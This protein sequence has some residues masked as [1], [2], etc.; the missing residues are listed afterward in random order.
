MCESTFARSDHL[1]AHIRT[2]NNNNNNNN[3]NITV[4]KGTNLDFKLKTSLTTKLNFDEHSITSDTKV[5]KDENKT[6]HCPYCPRVC[7][8]KHH[9]IPS[10][11]FC[12]FHSQ[13]RI[14]YD[15]IFKMNI[16]K[17]WMMNLI[18]IH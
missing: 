16:I 18:L 12:S 4:D 13:G 11:S 2:H 1:K 7:L 14:V 17:T 15:C 9:E 6:A 10:F 8:G 5:N 3:N